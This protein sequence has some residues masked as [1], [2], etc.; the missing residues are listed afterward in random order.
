MNARERELAASFSD[1]YRRLWLGYTR[2]GN[3][4]I[5]VFPIAPNS[6]YDMIFARGVQDFSLDNLRR[7]V[8]NHMEAR[9]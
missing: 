8:L 1:V 9:S 2:F 3:I 5:T 4:V 6:P 7:I